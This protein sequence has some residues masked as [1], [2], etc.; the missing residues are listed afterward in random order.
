[1]NRSTNLNLYLPENS[2]YRDVSQLTYNF[3]TIDSAVGSHEA[4]TEYPYSD[5]RAHTVFKRAG[6]AQITCV[7]GYWYNTG[8]GNILRLGSDSA[9]GW[10]LPE[11]VRPIAN[12]EIKEALN[13][14]RITIGTDG[15]VTCN[16]QITGLSLR[17]SGAWVCAN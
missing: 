4:I 17:F 14:K 6:I 3:E 15:G 13:G 2:D 9:S 5:S 12:V 8:A 1:M 16:E 7:G 10:L 11:A